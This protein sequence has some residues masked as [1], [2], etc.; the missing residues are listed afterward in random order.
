LRLIFVIYRVK[1]SAA[2][3]LYCTPAD[4]AGFVLP[5]ASAHEAGSVK[6]GD[7]LSVNA[8]PLGGYIQ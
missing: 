1:I 5:D 6:G 2:S 3:F 8:S 7:G 4:L